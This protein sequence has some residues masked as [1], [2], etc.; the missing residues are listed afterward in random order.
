MTKL[1]PP[2][3]WSRTTEF[4]PDA[5]RCQRCCR[6]GSQENLK[7]NGQLSLVTSK[8][9]KPIESSLFSRRERPQISDGIGVLNRNSVTYCG[10][11]TNVYNVPR[12]T[13]VDDSFLDSEHRARIHLH[14]LYF[15]TYLTF[16]ILCAF[17][18]YFICV[19][20]LA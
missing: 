3:L 20:P 5:D 9:I 17:Y 1:L 13:K 10:L 19:L 15:I 11:R 18:V 7:F 4:T 8:T 6:V 16:A 2:P 12:D 14:V